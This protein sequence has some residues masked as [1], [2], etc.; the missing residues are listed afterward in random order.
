MRKMLKKAGFVLATA[1]TMLT[2]SCTVN[3]GGSVSKDIDY[4]STGANRKAA[5]EIVASQDI[6][7][8]MLESR[9][10]SI[11]PLNHVQFRL[12][13]DVI[14]AAKTESQ[15][16]YQTVTVVESA[17]NN[18]NIDRVTFKDLDGDLSKTDL[19]VKF[20]TKV[21]FAAAGSNTTEK[22]FEAHGEGDGGGLAKSG[23]T[24]ADSILGK[25]R[26]QALQEFVKQY[27]A[28]L[29][30]MKSIP[31]PSTT[32]S[33][34]PGAKPSKDSTMPGQST[35]APMKDGKRTPPGLNK[36]K[37]PNHANGREKKNY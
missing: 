5:L 34:T 21:Q 9:G 30:T 15:A 10:T 28:Q 33:T 13:N 31:A 37:N 36:P 6:Q 4:S 2:A 25:A 20:D 3:P 16:Y 14:K 24:A 22:N 27:G 35:S 26:E 18:K 29:A 17:T 7:D 11:G 12:G 1:G 32:P 19:A 23:G 8:K